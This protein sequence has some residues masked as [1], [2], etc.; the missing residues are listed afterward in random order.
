SGYCVSSEALAKDSCDEDLNHLHLWSSRDT[1]WNLEP[2][3][4]TSGCSQ[5]YLL[6]ID[7]DLHDSPTKLL[8]RPG[9]RAMSLH[10]NL[11]ESRPLKVF[12]KADSQLQYDMTI[13]R[14]SGDAPCV[15]TSA[16]LDVA[17]ICQINQ[18]EIYGITITSLDDDGKLTPSYFSFD[19]EDDADQDSDSDMDLEVSLVLLNVIILTFLL[20]TVFI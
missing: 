6:G 16:T 2:A 3:I 12:R 4:M 14:A 19:C 15:V 13:R 7:L 8:W 9:K 18:R 11:W 5:Y 10:L 17:H 1:K 20:G